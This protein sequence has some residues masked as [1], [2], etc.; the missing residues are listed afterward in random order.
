MPATRYHPPPE[1]PPGLRFIRSL[2]PAKPLLPI[3]SALTSPTNSLPPDFFRSQ[4][5]ELILHLTISAVGNFHSR[6]LLQRLVPAQALTC[7]YPRQNTVRTRAILGFPAQSRQKPRPTRNILQI[8]GLASQSPI[9]AIH[10]RTSLQH[11]S[12]HLLQIIAYTRLLLSISRFM[13]QAAIPSNHCN[14]PQPG[15]GTAAL[16]SP[17]GSH[18]PVSRKIKGQKC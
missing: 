16:V 1:L 14:P 6:V 15:G 2:G 3:Q 18:L 8:A 5:V 17:L 10:S 7:T 4:T 12:T 9:T 11:S 13:Q